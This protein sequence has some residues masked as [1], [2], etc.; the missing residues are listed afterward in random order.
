[1]DKTGLE[2]ILANPTHY[3]G[4]YLEFLGFRLTAWRE[5][6]ARLEMPVRPDH[7]NTVGFLH[8]G[9]IASL[10]DIAGAV[11]GSHGIADEFVSITINLSCNYMAPH[12]G[13]TVIAEG[14][15]VRT[16]TSL[17][18]AQAKLLDPEH[19]LLCATATGTYKAKPR[20]P[21]Q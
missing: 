11:A 13:D 6:F 12:R 1:M 5:G 14:E 20:E 19:N 8:G 4:T 15:L 7:R 17:F 21:E 18:F 9:V 2:S 16:T 10:L 3:E